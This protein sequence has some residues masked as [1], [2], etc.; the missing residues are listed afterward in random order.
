MIKGLVPGRR[1]VFEGKRA[2]MS[3]FM[4]K[5]T[6][7]AGSIVTAIMVV[8]SIASTA[9]EEKTARLV[10][11]AAAHGS[12]DAGAALDVRRLPPTGAAKP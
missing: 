3:A 8:A 6:I 4:G 12:L 7:I 1:G 2:T 9:A 5:R 10:Q 11:Y